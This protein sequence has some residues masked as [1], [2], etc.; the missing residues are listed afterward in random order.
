MAKN[1]LQFAFVTSTDSPMHQDC[2]MEEND[3]QPTAPTT[4]V[5][6]LGMGGRAMRA[7]VVRQFG[8]PENILIENAFPKPT[9]KEG[10]VLVRVH[11]AGVNPVDTYIRSGQYAN[12]PNL[13][14]VPG[15][16]GAGIVEEI[17]EGV[18][19]LKPGDRVWFTQPRTGSAAQYA[20]VSHAYI[21]PEQ[22]SF[23]QGAAIGIA[24]MTAFRALFTKAQARKGQSVLIHGASGGVGLAACQLA[25]SAGLKVVGTAGTE[26]GVSIA[27]QNGAEFVANHREMEYVRTLA[28]LYP[29]GFDIVLEMLANVNLSH[30]ASLVARYGKICVIG[31]RGDIQINPRVLMQ[32]ESSIIGVMLFHNTRDDYDNMGNEISKLIKYGHIKPV[33]GKEFRLEEMPAAHHEVVNQTGTLGKIVVNI[34]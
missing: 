19:E 21:L 17:G 26:A 31:S 23:S 4:M 34:P 30:D 16:E 25:A 8:S 22:L 28:D 9:P 14:Y 27:R 2:D 11:A 12:L 3:D 5:T 29:S 10:E 13:P 18:T 7:A 33:V 32:K 6:V 1:R 20:A 15:R 24:Y